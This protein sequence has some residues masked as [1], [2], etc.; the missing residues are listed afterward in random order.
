MKKAII[1][2]GMLA[3]LFLVVQP[4][5]AATIRLDPHGSYY[6]EPTMVDSPATFQVYVTAGGDPTTDPHILLVMTESCFNGLT[7][8]V[9][10]TWGATGLLT[11]TKAEFAPASVLSDKVPPE[12]DS[13][14]GYTVAALKD[15]LA[16]DVPVYWAFGAILDGAELTQTPQSFTVTLP[17]SD[18]RMMVYVLGKYGETDL[19]N[20]RVPPTQP[21]F[22][23]PEAATIFLAASSMMALGVVYAYKRKKP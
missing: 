14:N 8:D 13:G 2:F 6:G 20:N 9:T 1:A 16:T 18:P 5:F 4:V 12:A 23:V 10:V 22:V 17:S 11:I 15:H 3:L 19:F 21:G 7:G